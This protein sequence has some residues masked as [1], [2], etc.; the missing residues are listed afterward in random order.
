M[1]DTKWRYLYLQDPIQLQTWLEDLSLEGWQLERVWRTWGKFRRIAPNRIRYRVEPE[2]VTMQTTDGDI[3]EKDQLYADMGWKRAGTIMEKLAIYAAEDA[4]APEPHTDQELLQTLWRKVS[5]RLLFPN[6]GYL[7]GFLLSIRMLW[8][9]IF[10]YSAHILAGMSGIL[11]TSVAFWTLL[12]AQETCHNWRRCRPY[13]RMRR[14]DEEPYRTYSV[15]R[16]SQ[17]RPVLVLLLLLML[18]LSTVVVPIVESRNRWEL[19]TTAVEGDFEAMLPE[20]LLYLDGE[21]LGLAVGSGQEISA[22]RHLHTVTAHGYSDFSQSWD[23][24]NDTVEV[25]TEYYHMRNRYFTDL[26]QEK[27]L[28]NVKDLAELTCPDVDGAWSGVEDNLW[29]RD[30]V[31]IRRENQILCLRCSGEVDLTAYTGAMVEL[32]DQAVY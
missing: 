32:L 20:D 21:E 12:L 27:L 26:V 16:W 19:T 5:W 11:I 3:Q 31:L 7:I 9:W 30:F 24:G 2:Y 14:G 4:A 8:R 23:S 22:F 13:W 28:T 17:W 15:S 10:Q 18:C 29:E 1:K 25:V 6:I